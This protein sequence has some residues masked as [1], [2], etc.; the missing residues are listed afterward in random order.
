M[1]RDHIA[2]DPVTQRLERA[3]QWH[4]AGKIAQADAI[5]R[6]ILAAQPTHIEALRLHGVVCL[7][8]DRWEEAEQLLTHAQSLAPDNAAVLNNLGSLHHKRGDYAQAEAHFRDALAQDPRFY[9]AT[10]N[11]GNALQRQGK[12]ADAIA[13]YEQA[14]ATQPDL[15]APWNNLG[16]LQQQLGCNDTAIRLFQRAIAL[17]PEVPEHWNNLGIAYADNGQADLALAAYE[18]ALALDPQYSQALNNTGNLLLTMN[19][20]REARASFEAATQSNQHIPEAWNG[21]GYAEKLLGRL[22]PAVR[23]FQR[24]IDLNHAYAEA[25]NNLGLTYAD[26]GQL[27]KALDAFRAAL[28]IKPH[29]AQCHSNLLLFLNYH[30]DLHARTLC[31]AHMNWAATQE[32]H[33]QTT[34]PPT[35]AHDVPQRIG[36]V[37]ADLCRH[38]IGYFLL[39][40][41]R[42]LPRDRVEVICYYNNARED[43]LTQ[44]IKQHCAH[45]RT[46][47]HQ[48]DPQVF[49]RIR[50]DRIDVLF[51]LSGHTS[52]NRLKLFS[53]RPAPV[54][55]SWLGYPHTTGMDAMDYVL[56]DP[57]CLPDF[58]HW[59]FAEQV[60][61]L[62][63][64]RCCYEAPA[65]APEVH[66]LPAQTH[67][68]VTFA[69]FNNPVKLNDNTF[70]LWSE[71]L[72][73][74]D[75]SRL[76]LSWKTLNDPSV[77]DWIISSFAAHGIDEERLEL[78]GGT[79]RHQ[80]VFAD[81]QRVDI[82][83]DTTP[84]S[85]GLTSCEAL[86]MGV[87]IVTL[88]G[89]R[90]ASR[91]TAGLLVHVGLEDLV[92]FTPQSYA[93][94]AV[95]LAHAVTRLEY[96]RRHL[97]ARMTRSCLCDGQAFAADFM[98]LLSRLLAEHA[99][100]GTTETQP[101]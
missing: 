44:A 46:I 12:F 45:W 37:S 59:Q 18:K 20:Y 31:D 26:Q 98:Q 92:C 86:W 76:M 29:Y 71:I 50:E 32:R 88:A 77:R 5:Y 87:P 24:A 60:A 64:S 34:P 85:G 82:A 35:P 78:L 48:P 93:D 90:P 3:K 16:N 27:D 30:A 56:S 10:N 51:D 99:D 74:C 7:D 49:D 95:E 97:R 73:R 2:K 89:K 70:A 21:V 94:R 9:Q 96:L 66:A 36:F 28:K 79:R 39:P 47:Y 41:L 84:F 101:C 68:G 75:N 72:R 14:L 63:H 25:W 83:L 13:A 91:Q 11:L 8:T 4:R 33:A 15:A 38:P 19:R 69:S 61:L 81:Y 55:I 100:K 42:H 22:Q 23:H 40:L 65:Y 57:I 58:T 80:Q 1:T 52:H 6:E 53:M 62:P 67:P 54:Q 43:D 17:A